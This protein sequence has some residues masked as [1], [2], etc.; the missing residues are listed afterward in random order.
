ME[1][2]GC[3]PSFLDRNSDPRLWGRIWGSGQDTWSWRA[4]KQSRGSEVGKGLSPESLPLM[5]PRA[6]VPCL[7]APGRGKGVLSA[8]KALGNSANQQEY[9]MCAGCAQPCAWH[10]GEDQSQPVNLGSGAGEIRR[11]GQAPTLIE[12]CMPD[13]VRHFHP[14]PPLILSRIKGSGCLISS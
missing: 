11:Q 13:T 8:I 5:L 10:H 14:L 7:G 4:S 12:G 6:G 3:Q 1:K 2:P 9:F